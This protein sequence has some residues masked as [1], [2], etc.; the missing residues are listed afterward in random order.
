MLSTDM[1]LLFIV[2]DYP[3]HLKKHFINRGILSLWKCCDVMLSQ[4]VLAIPC[5]RYSTERLAQLGW[6][7]GMTSDQAVLRA[8]DEIAASFPALT[9]LR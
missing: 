4:R 9:N 6:R 1:N 8:I 7:P 5:F 2:L 3:R